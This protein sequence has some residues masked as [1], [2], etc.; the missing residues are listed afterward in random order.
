MDFLIPTTLLASGDKN[1][2]KAGIIAVNPILD[3]VVFMGYLGI[4]IFFALTRLL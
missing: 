2:A 1:I 4:L 3:Y